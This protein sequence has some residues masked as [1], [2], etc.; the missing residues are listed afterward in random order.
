MKSPECFWE[1]FKG[2]TFQYYLELARD[3]GKMI[4]LLFNTENSSYPLF[5][6]FMKNL[7][8]QLFGP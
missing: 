1:S 2:I 3:L 4:F 7:G 8:K 6:G 5:S